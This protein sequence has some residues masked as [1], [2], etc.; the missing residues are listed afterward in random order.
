ML[1]TVTYSGG[2]DR[3]VWKFEPDGA[4]RESN[5]TSH[6]RASQLHVEVDLQQHY[7]FLWLSD[8]Q[9]ILRAAIL[10][11]LVVSVAAALKIACGPHTHNYLA[12]GMYTARLDVARERASSGAAALALL[13]RLCLGQ[14]Q[15][16]TTEC[17]RGVVGRDIEI[18]RQRYGH[19]QCVYPA[20][21]RKGPWCIAPRPHI[22]TSVLGI[23]GDP[24]RHA[25]FEP[26][27]DVSD[28][29]LCAGEAE[30]EAEVGLALA[31][32]WANRPLSSDRGVRAP[33][34]RARRRGGS[35]GGRGASRRNRRKGVDGD[36]RM[37]AAS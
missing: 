33:F 16:Y 3:S 35:W 22:D 2:S 25:L 19:R 5:A 23:V 14:V 10:V 9:R 26:E 37:H 34:R 29:L 4:D 6:C 11:S 27:L 18:Q 30:A 28:A 24:R 7:S 31:L 12:F 36:V 21:G 17:A 13:L 15:R 32:P 1:L 20:R 8:S